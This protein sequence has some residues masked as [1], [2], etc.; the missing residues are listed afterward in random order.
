MRLRVIERVNKKKIYFGDEYSE[1]MD[2]EYLS[3]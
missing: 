2:D 3:V 1:V